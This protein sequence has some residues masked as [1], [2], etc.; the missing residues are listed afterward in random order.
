[1]GITGMVLLTCK[2]TLGIT[3]V[4]VMLSL[5]RSWKLGLFA[6][7]AVLALLE[8]KGAESIS[9]S[10]IPTFLECIATLTELVQF[11]GMYWGFDEKPSMQI[12]LYLDYPVLGIFS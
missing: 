4:F 3:T 6:L 9:V 10:L 1:M 7:S 5:I 8:Q 11:Y 2:V 12:G